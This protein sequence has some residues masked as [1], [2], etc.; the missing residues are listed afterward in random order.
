MS[1]IASSRNGAGILGT[2]WQDFRIAYNASDNPEYLGRTEKAGATV[3]LAEAWQ[4]WKITYD[5]DNVTR[6]EGPLTGTWEG[7]GTLSWT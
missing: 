5:G 2:F 3:T 6:I 7:R 1:R 4:V